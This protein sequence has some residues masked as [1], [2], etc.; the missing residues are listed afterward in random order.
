MQMGIFFCS[1][2]YVY[3]LYRVYT[4]AEKHCFPGAGMYTSRTVLG[5]KDDLAGL[6]KLRYRIFRIHGEDK[7]KK[8]GQLAAEMEP[9]A[10][11]APECLKIIRRA[12]AQTHTRRTERRAALKICGRER[13]NILHELP[14]PG[15]SGTTSW[16]IG[17]LCSGGE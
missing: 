14:P 17:P 9:H 5:R 4:L 13:R 12:H 1:P 7:L 16:L 3:I 2:R 15:G 11:A 10:R 6:K 8:Y